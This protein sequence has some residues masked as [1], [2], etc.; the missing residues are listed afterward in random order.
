MFPAAA[1][2][3]LVFHFRRWLPAA[4]EEA[5]GMRLAPKLYCARWLV[6]QSNV[7]IA[8]SNRQTAHQTQTRSH[9]YILLCGGPGIFR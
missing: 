4:G 6:I 2:L 1:R 9:L 8:V 3:T 7:L 5:A